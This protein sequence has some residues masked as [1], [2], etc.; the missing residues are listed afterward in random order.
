MRKGENH[1]LVQPTKSPLE[2]KLLSSAILHQV[3]P[4]QLQCF[5]SQHDGILIGCILTAT[6]KAKEP[7]VTLRSIAIP[8]NRHVDGE[9]TNFAK[10]AA[11]IDLHK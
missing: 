3:P 2:L 7:F 1:L 6:K 5:K 9:Q 8:E 10:T 11:E 4:P